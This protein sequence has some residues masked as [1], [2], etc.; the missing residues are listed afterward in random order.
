MK[1]TATQKKKLAG[2]IKHITGECGCSTNSKT[3]IYW[4]KVDGKDTEWQT[5]EIIKEI[6]KL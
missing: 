5:K 1:L 2:K 6:E 4:K 3:C